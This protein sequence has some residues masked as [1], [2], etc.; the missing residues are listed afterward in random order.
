M[1]GKEVAATY[2]NHLNFWLSGVSYRFG[3]GKMAFAQADSLAF[4]PWG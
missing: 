3:Y 1:N 2:F 4:T